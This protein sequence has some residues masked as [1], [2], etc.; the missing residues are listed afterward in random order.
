MKQMQRLIGIGLLSLLIAA[1][2][3]CANVKPWEREALAREDMAWDP[4]PLEA[5]IR[6]HIQYSKETSLGAGGSGGGVCGCN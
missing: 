5:G 4:D 6:S 3:G 2:T 1:V